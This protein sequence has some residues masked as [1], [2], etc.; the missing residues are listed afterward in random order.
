MTRRR[1]RRVRRVRRNRNGHLFP[2]IEISVYKYL[3]PV[4]NEAISS[5]D[6]HTITPIRHILLF[7]VAG[8]P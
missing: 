5:H 4:D 7:L 3:C 8:I 2:V 1:V 6:G